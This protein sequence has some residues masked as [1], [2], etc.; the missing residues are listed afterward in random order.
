MALG[1]MRMSPLKALR[2]RCIDCSGGSASEVRLCALVQQ[3]S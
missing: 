1:H 3:T 2:L